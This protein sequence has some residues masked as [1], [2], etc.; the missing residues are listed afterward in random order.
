[1]VI[2]DES[3]AVFTKSISIWVSCKVIL[4]QIPTNI[5]SG[6]VTQINCLPT[7]EESSRVN[8]V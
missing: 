7:S 3:G 1:M 4:P 2:S 5:V 8:S 6:Q